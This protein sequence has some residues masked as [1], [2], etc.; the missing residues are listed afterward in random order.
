MDIESCLKTIDSFRVSAEE[1]LDAARRLRKVFRPDMSAVC[2][3]DL[4]CHSFYSDGYCSPTMRVFEAFR[5]KMKAI[6]IA[7]HDVF[8]G[9]LEAIE[10]GRFFEIDVI[11]ATEFYTDRSGIEIIAHFPDVKAFLKTLESGV[12]DEVVEPVREAKKKQLS[13]ML[14]RI[15][16]CFC[17]MG[18]KAEIHQEDIDKFLRNGI[19]TK[20]D[21]SVVMWQKYG[22]ELKRSGIAEDVKDFQAKYTTQDEHLNLPLEIDMD[23]SP[24]AFVRRIRSWGGLPGLPHP[25]ELRKKEGLGNAELRAIIEQLALEG[26][27]SMEVDGWR[28][29][30]CPETGMHQTELFNSMRIE[31]NAAHPD[32]RPLLFTNG[33]DDHNQPGEGLE[34][35]SGRNENLNPAFGKYENIALLRARA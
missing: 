3:I 12:F 33:S 15:P 34:L 14:K 2:E 7:D 31:H 22:P 27:Q 13:A 8:D 11:P 1:R 9:Q 35:G 25:S 20:G 30:I 19:S 24:E 17:K 32:K 21:I 26:L 16:D 29:G 18:F 10:A 4:H 5:R 23:L 6:A 28:N